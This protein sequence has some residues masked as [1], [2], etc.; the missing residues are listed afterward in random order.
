MKTKNAIATGD[1]DAER[2]GDRVTIFRVGNIWK[3]RFQFD[4]KQQRV[5]LGTRSKKEA[6]RRALMLEAELIEGKYKHAA[7]PVALTE[8]FAAYREYQVSLDRATRTLE[9]TDLVIRRATELA[10]RIRVRNINGLS[11]QFID[12]YRAK[13]KLRGNDRSTV[14]NHVVI[15]KQ[16]ANFAVSRNLL[17]SN[18]LAQLKIKKVRAKPQPCWTREETNRILAIC[19]SPQREPLRLLAETGLRFGELQHLT[20]EDVDLARGVLHIREKTVAI[21]GRAIHWKPKSGD[22]RA[23]PLSS[24]VRQIFEAM[25]RKHVWIFTSAPSK[26]YPTGGQR[27][28]GRRLLEYLQR[29][30]RKLGLA[31]KLHTFRHAFISHALMRGTPEAILRDWVGHVDA[32]ILRRYTHIASDAS[33]N[34]MERLGKDDPGE[35]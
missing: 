3:A 22:Q 24:V 7:P 2:I 28:S 5:T 16:I 18:P 10:E 11:L 27:L 32:Q 29:R 17:S 26:Q 31:G 15:L 25:P 21:A 14:E 6:R 30:L 13:E 4:G 23:V 1:D 33:R 34:A 9:K 35:S 20:W 12:K 19:A 8:V